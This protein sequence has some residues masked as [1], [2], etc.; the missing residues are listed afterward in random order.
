MAL[1]SMRIPEAS[2]AHE[3]FSVIAF[4]QVRVGNG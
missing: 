2:R 3:V 4:V 1:C